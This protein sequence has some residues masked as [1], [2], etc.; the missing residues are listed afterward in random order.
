LP[1]IITISSKLVKNLVVPRQASSK[2]CDNDTVL[3]GGGSRIYLG[4]P[5]VA[6]MAALRAGTDLIYGSS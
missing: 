3:V 5:L 2:K 1:E 6:S 4:A